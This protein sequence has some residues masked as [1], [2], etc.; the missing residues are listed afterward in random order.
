MIDPGWCETA[1]IADFNKDGRP[2]IASCES[3]YE[4]PNWMRHPLREINYTNG[5]IDNF[6]DLAVDVDGD[7]YTDLIQ[8]E[9]FNRRLLWLKNPGK[10]GS[11]WVENEIDRAGPHPIRER[12]R[13]AGARAGHERQRVPVHGPL[14]G[15][16]EASI[17]ERDDG[18]AI[19][20]R[21][22]A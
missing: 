13:A 14:G 21:S 1:A 22:A 2:D 6:S 8:I 3:W 5:Y 15:H 4:A 9:Y 16:L 17:A 18:S 7:G 11:A 10:A 12:R 19:A 20:P